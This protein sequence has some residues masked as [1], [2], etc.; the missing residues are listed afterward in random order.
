MEAQ[1]KQSMVLKLPLLV[2]GIGAALFF[3]PACKAQS[4]VSPD[5]F[6][7]T[8]SWA[9]A[10]QTVHAP[11]QKHTIAKASVQE[12]SQKANQVST[13]QLAAVREVS[14]PANYEAVAA[15]RQRKPADGHPQKQ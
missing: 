3:T 10:A 7:G 6:D 4:E 1:V 11:M 14:K 2:L 12:N 13:L 15:D 5:H 8:D 9:R